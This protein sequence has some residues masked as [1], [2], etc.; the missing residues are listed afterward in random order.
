MQNNN[1]TDIKELSKELLTKNLNKP[2]V[3]SCRVT[4]DIP[5]DKLTKMV[6]A[7]VLYMNEPDD[8]FLLQTPDEN[9]QKD[10]TLFNLSKG[11]A[12]EIEDEQKL[13]TGTF[14]K[15]SAIVHSIKNKLHEFESLPV[16]MAIM[17][18]AYPTHPSLVCSFIT[19]QEMKDLNKIQ[20]YFAYP[21]LKYDS[22]QS[23]RIRGYNIPESGRDICCLMTKAD[24]PR[25]EAI[26]FQSLDGDTK[27]IIK[28]G[29]KLLHEEYM[30]HVKNDSLTDD[31]K[32]QNHKQ[33]PKLKL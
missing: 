1:N 22:V 16:S 11:Y 23:T 21:F 7:A 8:F 19:E 30:K 3:L 6:T 25:K 24:F 14:G 27:N 28:E 12:T 31:K 5:V 2:I 26:N 18:R 20:E 4:P 33:K 13:S 17:E 32:S 9:G 10:Y 15:I 29:G